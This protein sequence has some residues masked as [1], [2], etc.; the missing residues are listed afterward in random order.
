MGTSVQVMVT[1]VQVIEI[2]TQEIQL[3]ELQGFKL[4]IL[5][6]LERYHNI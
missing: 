6:D 4:E 3:I 5:V 2:T 1:T